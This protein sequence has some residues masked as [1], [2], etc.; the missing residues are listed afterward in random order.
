MIFIALRNA[1]AMKKEY[2]WEAFFDTFLL[3]EFS[4]A[5]KYFRKGK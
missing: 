5:H 3:D 4:Y 1:F 2:F